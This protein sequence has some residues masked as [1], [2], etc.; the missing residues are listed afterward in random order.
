MLS[1]YIGGERLRY[2]T[3]KSIKVK[4]WNKETNLPKEIKGNTDI[5]VFLSDLKNEIERYSINAHL[6]QITPTKDRLKAHLDIYLKKATP[7]K[8]TTLLDY[9]K[10]YKEKNP[11]NLQPSTIQSYTTLELHLNTFQ[12]ETGII[13]YPRDITTDFNQDFKKFL[14]DCNLQNNTITKYVRKLKVIMKWL[15][16]VKKI[17]VPSDYRHF[18]TSEN[19]Q[20]IVYLTQSEVIQLYNHNSKLEYLNRTKDLFLFGV[21]T[22]LR[23][24]DLIRLTP[25]NIKADTLILQ[26]TQKTQSYASI[27]L[28]SFA[29]AIL[30][31]YD[32]NLPKISNQKANV[33]LK[34]VCKEAGIN[35]TVTL[36]EVKGADRVETTYPK[37][38][39]ISMHDS[40]RSHIVLSLELG[41]QTETLMKLTTHKDY[42]SFARYVEIAEATKKREML[43]WENLSPLKA[44]NE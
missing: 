33:Y 34:Q 6:N 24:S 9:I 22:G 40:R 1:V 23:F 11:E 26:T 42:S 15:E 41:V 14:L 21:F 18:K 3:A 13:L 39:V 8:E 37:H 30:A 16:L 38:E 2:S 10:E 43:K 35:D 5:R 44:V 4:D 32:N 17:N 20:T 25:D 36:T 12:A 29:K 27:P 7:A 31:K 19:L 28:N